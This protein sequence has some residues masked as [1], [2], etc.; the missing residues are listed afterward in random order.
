MALL[1]R[2]E[3]SVHTCRVCESVRAYMHVSVH[4]YSRARVLCMCAWERGGGSF[5]IKTQVPFS[6][7]RVSEQSI[8]ISMDSKRSNDSSSKNKTKE[9]LLTQ[10]FS[11]PS[12]TIKTAQDHT[13]N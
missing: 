11:H 1:C 13:K 10:F 6:P 3:S 4:I 8:F 12:V 7:P 2:E 5:N 9:T